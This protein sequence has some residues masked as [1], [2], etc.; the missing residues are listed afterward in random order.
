MNMLFYMAKLAL[1]VIKLRA[2]IWEDCPSRLNVI[3]RVLRQGKQECQE[4]EEI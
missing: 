4:P 1:R 2:L 3:K